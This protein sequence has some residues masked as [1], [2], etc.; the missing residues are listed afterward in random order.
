MSRALPVASCNCRTAACSPI[1]AT[2]PPSMNLLWRKV[3]GD[4]RQHRVQ[5]ALIALV[6]VLGASAV[7]A[8]FNGY[9]VLKREIKRSYARANSPD[10]ALWFDVVPPGVVE[11]LRARPGVA[12]A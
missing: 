9:A 2:P 4:L 11:A 12:E 1:N 10:I 5:V 6:L 3:R 8:A 7:V